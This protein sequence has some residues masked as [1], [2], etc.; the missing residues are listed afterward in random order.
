MLVSGPGPW[1]GSTSPRTLELA[2]AAAEIA[3][4]GLLV[5]AS[6]SC[7]TPSWQGLV[8]LAV[9]VLCF[10]APL[11]AWLTA[12]TW[13][14]MDVPAIAVVGR[15][16][17]AVAGAAGVLAGP[18]P[19][20]LGGTLAGLL[21]GIDAALS[22][23]GVGMEVRAAPSLLAFAR[24]GLHIGA[25]IGFVIVTQVRDLDLRSVG[26]RYGL[27]WIAIAIALGV[28]TFAQA[29]EHRSA[30]ERLATE[31]DTRASEHRERAHWI[32]DDVCSELRYVR[33]RIEHG[34]MAGADVSSALDELDHRLRLRQLDELLAS[35]TVRLADLLQPFV[36]TLQDR[37]VR[38]WDVPTFEEADRVV[39]ERP[40]R[41]IRRALSVLVMNGVNA[42]ATEMAIRCRA[43][44]PD[45][46]L[47]VEDD[48]GGFDLDDTQPGRGLEVLRRELGA[49]SL[50]VNRTV[51]GSIVGAR[52]AGAIP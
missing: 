42:G 12:R 40:A 13:L 34:T 8:P 52:I 14:L 33:L 38:V 31:R 41:D 51:A 21:L 30:E 28:V 24:S 19:L 48:A 50:W 37:G 22:L 25:G 17:G 26:A 7:G 2:L 6:L 16:V 35:G 11:V 29:L 18:L 15:S 44:P 3:V 39:R 9:G 4:G 20:V 49:E 36:R 43:T 10:T 1:W 27:L 23:R 47:E 5:V 45:M 46:V 32:H